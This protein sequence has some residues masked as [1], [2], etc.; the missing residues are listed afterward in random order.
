MFKVNLSD[1]VVLTLLQ[2]QLSHRVVLCSAVQCQR[3]C[4]HWAGPG[5][6]K[7]HDPDGGL[8]LGW[9]RTPPEPGRPPQKGRAC[10]GG[11]GRT[12][13]GAAWLEAV[14]SQR[15]CRSASRWGSGPRRRSCPTLKIPSGYSGDQAP[16]PGSGSC[17]KSRWKH[18]AKL[19]AEINTAIY[20]LIFYF[21]P[22]NQNLKQWLG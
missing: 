2:I 6:R 12:V 10:W 1:L 3:S 22:K 9:S 17:P 13:T 8:N 20:S 21:K 7:R 16:L 11:S 14:R 5:P 19:K 4:C 18:W 15:L